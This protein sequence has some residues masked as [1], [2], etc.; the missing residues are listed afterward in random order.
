M[1]SARPEPRK[2]YAAPTLTKL[3]SEEAKIF[4]LEQA[5]Q[6]DEKAK[7]LLNSLSQTSA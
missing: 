1:N 4:L 7:E 2:K 3:A 6:G 5:A